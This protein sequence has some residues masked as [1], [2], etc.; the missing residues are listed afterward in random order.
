MT[1]LAD[2][3]R[4]APPSSDAD[5]AD[6]AENVLALVR[7]FKKSRERWLAA[8][9][10]DVEWSA[11]VLL[12]CLHSEGAMRA[13]A[14]AESLQSDPS[15]V[16]RQVASLVKDGM[17]E[18]RSDPDDGRA[19]IL[20][21]TPRAE[22]VLA[23]HDKIRLTHFEKMLAGWSA[24]DITQLAALLGRFTEAYEVAN[25]ELITEKIAGR[26]ARTGSNA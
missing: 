25:S 26:S 8:A 4:S 21:L 14:V 18:R 22:Q 13:G 3:M 11:Q 20:V 12:K 7:T 16:S 1:D 2:D 24:G 17:L 23:E 10:H 19:S 6:L 15:T 5:I 9:A